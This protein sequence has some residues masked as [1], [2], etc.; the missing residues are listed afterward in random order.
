[1]KKKQERMSVNEYKQLETANS[2]MESLCFID[3]KSIKPKRN[4]QIEDAEKKLFVKLMRKEFPVCEQFLIPLDL[5]AVK[6]SIG[7]AV[8]LK[9]LGAKKGVADYLLSMPNHLMIYNDSTNCYKSCTFDPKYDYRNLY[10]GLFIEF[11][12]DK[13]DNKPKGKQSKDQKTFEKLVSG[14]GYKYIIVYSADEAMK[15]VKQYLGFN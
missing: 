8:K 7:Q 5:H 11:K 3:N 15:E 2:M 9:S 6:L 10:H 1:M 4:V 14:Q 13:Y 12:R